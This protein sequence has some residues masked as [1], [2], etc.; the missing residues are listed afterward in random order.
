[1]SK[2]AR[3]KEY[4]YNHFRPSDRGIVVYCSIHAAADEFMSLILS[5]AVIEWWLAD[6]IDCVCM[7]FDR[8]M[9][10]KLGGREAGLGS[11]I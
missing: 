9:G 8:I 4:I 11:R 3:E 10:D 5:F 6:F 2:K 1:M 7:R